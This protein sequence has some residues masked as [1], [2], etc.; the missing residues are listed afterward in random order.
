MTKTEAHAILDRAIHDRLVPFIDIINALE[1]T[2]DLSR[3]DRATDR[4]LCDYG[5]E[6][7][8]NRS[9]S[10]HGGEAAR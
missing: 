9:R 4:T 2:G 6:S 3:F 7:R 8:F 10:L 5:N 1:T